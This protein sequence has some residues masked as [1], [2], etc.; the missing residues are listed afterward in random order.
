MHWIAFKQVKIS[1]I[2]IL[3]SALLFLIFFAWQRG[4][5]DVYAYKSQAY[6]A[7]WTSKNIPPTLMQWQE[8]YKALTS[9][10]EYSPSQ[11]AYLEAMGGLWELKLFIEELADD[12]RKTALLQSKNYYQQSIQLRPAWPDAWASLAVV[13]QKSDELDEEYKKSIERA[14]TLGP[15]EVN[16]QIMIAEAT[17]PVWNLLDNNLQQLVIESSIRGLK[18]NAGI[19]SKM[20]REFG[21][22]DMICEKLPGSEPSMPVCANSNLQR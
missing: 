21:A 15:W 19:Y 14:T 3:I 13:K 18:S 9:A 22:L 17:L 12:Q 8:A 20:L 16:V 7:Q 10:L 2:A 6:I 11:P 4:V 5:A 1:S